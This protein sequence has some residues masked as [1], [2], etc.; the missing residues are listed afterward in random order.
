MHRRAKQSKT[1]F[2]F[3]GFRQVSIDVQA[4]GSDLEKK[5]DVAKLTKFDELHQQNV[6]MGRDKFKTLKQIR[7]G[8]T[9]TRVLDFE[10]M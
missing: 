7:S 4:L 3:V 5:K 6:A 10:K 2:W 8:N 9:K 1:P